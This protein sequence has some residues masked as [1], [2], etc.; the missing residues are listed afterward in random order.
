MNLLFRY[1]PTAVKHDSSRKGHKP[2]FF[3]IVKINLFL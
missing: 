1:G 3:A 2:R